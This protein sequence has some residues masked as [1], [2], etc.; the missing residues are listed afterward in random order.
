MKRN[1]ASFLVVFYCLGLVL[2]AGT[3]AIAG[4][5][6]PILQALASAGETPTVLGDDALKQVRGKN[7][8]YI[9][10]NNQYSVWYDFYKNGSYVTTKNLATY[11][12]NP[13][14]TKIQSGD[15][16]YID[17]SDST[18]AFTTYSGGGDVKTIYKNVVIKYKSK[19]WGYLYGYT[20]QS[21][22]S[23]SGGTFNF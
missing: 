14:K 17:Q 5:Q 13:G 8:Y 2:I 7:I 19:A 11:T 15:D 1:F 22:T 4:E 12:I 21:T 9:T 3:A 20:P 6:P 10:L 23:L 16:T 18:V